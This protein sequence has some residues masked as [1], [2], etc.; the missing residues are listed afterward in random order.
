MSALERDELKTFS[1]RVQEFLRNAKKQAEE[2]REFCRQLDRDTVDS[3]D[4]N[5]FLQACDLK[6]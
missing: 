5:R 6:L 3:A 4:F 1:P 2:D